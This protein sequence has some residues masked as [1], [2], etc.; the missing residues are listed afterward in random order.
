MQ[1]TQI[2]ITA[3]VATFNVER[4]IRRCIE[5]LRWA[6][7]ILVVDSFSTDRTVE[8]CSQLGCRVLQHPYE[9]Y[10]AQYNWAIQHAKHEWILIFDSDEVCT[11]ELR[12]EI[13]REM[14][15]PKCAGYAIRRKSYFLGRWI[16]YSGWQNDC[17]TRLFRRDLGRFIVRHVHS[18]FQL[19]GPLGKFKNPLLHYPYDNLDSWM[20]RFHRYAV[21]SARNARE[22]G[23]KPSWA[24]ISLRPAARFIRAYILKLGFLDGRQGFIIAMFSMFSVFMRYLYLQEM[25][26]GTRES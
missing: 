21:W 8:I 2:P 1:A 13:R 5:S 17:P 9:S 6:D 24:S 19:D 4:K 20:E 3:V 18:P 26:N 12:D 23:D 15:D 16:K 10:G 22:R 11:C 7:E 25:L 14:R